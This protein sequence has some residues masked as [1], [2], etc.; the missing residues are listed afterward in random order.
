LSNIEIET[1]FD[2]RGDFRVNYTKLDP[3][4]LATLH[5]LNDSHQWKAYRDLLIN[6]KNHFFNSTL[7]IDD[8][9]KLL[10]H[11]GIVAGINFAINQL[12]I[13]V[14]QHKKALEKERLK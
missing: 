14:Q 9:T 3:E 12:P 5:T 13:L 2:E 11:I 8:T 7:A 1:A 6:A 10:K 4:L